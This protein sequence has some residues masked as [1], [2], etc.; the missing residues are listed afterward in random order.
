M[1]PTSL[2]D[3]IAAEI[4]GWRAVGGSDATLPDHLA[5]WFGRCIAE[6][7]AERDEAQMEWWLPTQPWFTGERYADALRRIEELEARLTRRVENLEDY[8]A[9]RPD[10]VV[11][12]DGQQWRV[13]WLYDATEGVRFARL[14]PVEDTDE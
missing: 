4:D 2:R 13:T 11:V 8:L 10:D 7:E 5:D 3:E 9:R 6:L 12:I 1:S 14:V